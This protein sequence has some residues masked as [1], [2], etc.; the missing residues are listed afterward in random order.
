MTDQ[1]CDIRPISPADLV[2]QFEDLCGLLR[3]C[4]QEGAAIGF[5]A[6][7]TQEEAERFWRRDIGAALASGERVLLGAYLGRRLVGTVQVIL[8]MPQNQPH[9]AEIAKMMVHPESRRRRV[10]RALMERALTEARSAGR[11][12]VTLDTRTGDVS[13]LFYGSAGF[14]KAGVI[15]GYAYDPDGQTLHGTT[16]MYRAI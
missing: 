9:R 14:Q 11:T 4:V 3:D 1:T 15:P 16:L 8:A 2:H 12:L 7:I 5:L 13:E 6:A 10:G